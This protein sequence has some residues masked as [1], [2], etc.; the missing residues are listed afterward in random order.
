MVSTVNKYYL[1]KGTTIYTVQQS[2]KG[3]FTS[4]EEKFLTRLLGFCD[5]F[6]L[7]SGWGELVGWRKIISSIA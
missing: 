5:F 7:D 2:Y 6:F 3:Y 4:N 1:L